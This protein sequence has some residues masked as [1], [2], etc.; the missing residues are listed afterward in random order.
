MVAP[1]RDVRVRP[2]GVPPGGGAAGVEQGVLRGQYVRARVQVRLRDRFRGGDVGRVPADV[3]GGGAGH[4]RILPG[5]GAGQRV[6][7][8]L[9]ARAIAVAFQ[10]VPV[11]GRGAVSQDAQQHGG[12]AVD[13]GHAGGRQVA[14]VRDGHARHDAA[15]Q[16]LQVGAHGVGQRLRAPTRER[17]ADRVAQQRQH[18]RH[19]GRAGRAQRQGA[20]RGQSGPQGAG[21]GRAEQRVS[22]QC[23]GRQAPQPEVGQGHGV[24][25]HARQRAQNVV[26]QAL[27]VGQQRGHQAHP[28]RTV[29]AQGVGGGVQVAFQRHAAST[30][31]RVRDGGAGLHPVQPEGMQRPLPER[32]ARGGQRVNGRP[33]IMHE[34]GQGHVRAAQAAAHLRARLDHLH[35]QARAG[36][37]DGR[38]QAVRSGSDNHGVQRGGR[39]CGGSSHAGSVPPGAGR[40]C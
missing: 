14:G 35:A 38:R 9:N 27:P 16:V 13:Q 17:P 39:S 6:I 21:L 30:G 5:H 29:A 28:G 1:V 25:R 22:Q 8:L 23:S 19:G 15:A 10:R 40:P 36:Q 4:A 37:G 7:E 12:T 26:Q 20:V 33:V 31:Q 24:A 2:E 18:Q 11:R 34:A 3:H 32:G